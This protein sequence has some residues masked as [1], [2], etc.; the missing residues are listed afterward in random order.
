MA[1][2]GVTLLSLFSLGALVG[3]VAA[4]VLLATALN[5][6]HQRAGKS[7]IVNQTVLPAPAPST[8]DVNQATL[9]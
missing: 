3:L 1:R 4:L 8:A 5:M 9:G 6:K 7:P 2:N